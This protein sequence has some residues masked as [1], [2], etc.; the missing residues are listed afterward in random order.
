MKH[1][2][3]FNPEQPLLFTHLFFWGF[4]AVCLLGYSFIYKVNK[5]RS[6]YLLLFSFFF[7]YKTNSVFILLLMF[8]IVSDFVGEG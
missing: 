2:L 1:I 7:Y 4:F 5:A 6:I 3:Q 8:T